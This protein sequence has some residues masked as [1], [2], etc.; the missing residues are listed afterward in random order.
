MKSKIVA[1]KNKAGSQP[2]LPGP[3]RFHRAQSLAVFYLDPA[4]PQA[5]PGPGFKTMIKITIYIT[6]FKEPIF[7]IL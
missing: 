1:K 5:R 3:T 4:W 6:K 2:S 7:Q